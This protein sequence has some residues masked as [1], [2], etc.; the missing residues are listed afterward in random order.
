VSERYSE[1]LPQEQPQLK[2]WVDG[3]YG[4]PPKLDT[5]NKALW[6]ADGAGASFLF[7]V[8]GQL[9]S[10]AQGGSHVRAVWFVRDEGKYS[11]IG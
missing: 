9:A 5:N 11:F 6:I 3:P 2:V 7:S 4:G 10:R 8:A 1:E